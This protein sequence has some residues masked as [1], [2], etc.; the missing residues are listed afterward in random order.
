M[1]EERFFLTGRRQSFSV[2]VDLLLRQGKVC[3]CKSSFEDLLG[4]STV[5]ILRS[6][7]FRHVA[8]SGRGRRWRSNRRDQDH[9]TEVWHTNRACLLRQ[10]EANAPAHRMTD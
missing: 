10:V 5:G 7:Q 2:T 8:P 6:W 9:F 4:Q 3:W 1:R